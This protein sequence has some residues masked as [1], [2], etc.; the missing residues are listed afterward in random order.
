MEAFLSTILI[1]PPNFAPTGWALCAGQLMS[2]SQYTA[3][4][5]LLGTTYGGDGV[6]TFGLPDLRGRIPVGAGQGRGL[7][8]YNLGETGG[9]E[10]VTLTVNSLAAH[11]HT[12][13]PSG[14]SAKVPAVTSIGTTNQASPS[15]T[16][17]APV[18]AGRNP[19]N[20]YSTATPNQS[21]ASGSVTGSVS[22]A[23]AGGGQPH[24]NRQPYLSVNYIIALQG[25][26]P[27]RS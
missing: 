23:S 11:T 9:V 22:V 20:I 8:S 13:T 14:L 7:S 18:D 24:E 10:G 1:W 15:V 12:A 17:A 3:L 21:L 5:S 4:F 26:Y 6:S 27:S 25:I 19:I 16:L 2:I